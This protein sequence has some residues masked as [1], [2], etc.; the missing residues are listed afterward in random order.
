MEQERKGDE[1]CGK[2]KMKTMRDLM[3]PSVPD[4]QVPKNC[5]HL[6]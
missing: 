5:L 3:D 4:D 6:F 1:R 2:W